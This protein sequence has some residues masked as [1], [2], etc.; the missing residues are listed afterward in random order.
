MPSDCRANSSER[1]NS[2]SAQSFALDS[3]LNLQ[4]DQIIDAAKVVQLTPNLYRPFADQEANHHPSF[5]EVVLEYPGKEG[6]ERF[7]LCEPI[8]DHEYSPIRDLKYTVSFIA[9]QCCPGVDTSSLG[10]TE[11]GTVR[12]II[13]ACNRRNSHDLHENL[14]KFNEF[15]QSIRPRLELSS[16]V[17]G[18]PELINLILDQ[19]Y[20]RTVGPYVDS[21]RAYKGFSNY[22]YGEV[23]HSLISEFISKTGLS[24]GQCFL[25][26]GSGTGNAVLQV[27]SEALCESY[28]VEI[29]DNPAKLGHHQMVEFLARMKY[30]G[31]PCGQIRLKHADFLDDQ[32]THQIIKRADVIF[33]NN[34]AF[35]A[36]LNQRIMD[37]F[38]DLKD[39]AKVISLRSFA[40]VDRRLNLR[41]SNSIETI[42]RVKEFLFPQNSVSWMSEA[43]RYF[44]HTLKR[45]PD[46]RR[47]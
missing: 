44:I 8:K 25:D 28:G 3:T 32:E 42:F 23:K 20:A 14:K 37:L 4:A 38:L 43:G 9:L 16:T 34:Y 27:A 1:S 21:L 46:D 12:A 6:G 11:T 41:R 15:V 17:P 39:S 22:V 45:C 29:M 36:E 2:R 31:K 33:V 40:P 13:K 35:D 26:M 10:N 47:N 30:F 24:P 19:S 18:S 5:K 7:P